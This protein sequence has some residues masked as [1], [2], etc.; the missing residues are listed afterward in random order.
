MLVSRKE[1]K[2]KSLVYYFTNKPCKHG[3]VDKRFTSTGGCLGCSRLRKPDSKH[4]ER[5]KK[6]KARNKEKIKQFQKVYQQRPEVKARRAATQRHREYLK[7]G[8]SNLVKGLNLKNAIDNI[9]LECQNKTKDT[10]I[11]HHVDHIIPLKGTN[12]CGLHVPWNL[13]IL[14]EKENLCKSNKH[15]EV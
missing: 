13:Q 1:A 9:Y 3:H 10:G 11:M 2:Q 14:T 4:N 12:V 6:Y 8:S 7:Y 15:E 5:V